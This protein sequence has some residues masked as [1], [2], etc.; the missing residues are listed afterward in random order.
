MISSEKVCDGLLPHYGQVQGVQGSQGSQGLVMKQEG[1]QA[2]P[3]PGTWE[4]IQLIR[5]DN[6]G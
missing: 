3:E 1:R 5:Q 2:D 6:I 4:H